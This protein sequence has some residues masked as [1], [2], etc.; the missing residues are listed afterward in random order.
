[1]IVSVDGKP[2]SS[3]ALLTTVLAGLKPGQAAA[4]ALRRQTDARTTRVVTL[5]THPGS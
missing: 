2:T 3:T 4:V 5:G 1:V